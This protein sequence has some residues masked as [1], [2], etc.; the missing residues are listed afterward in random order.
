MVKYNLLEPVSNE[1]ASVMLASA[2]EAQQGNNGS[3]S[4]LNTYWTRFLVEFGK[5]VD[6]KA[7]TKRIGTRDGTLEV[8]DEGCGSSLTLLQA[9]G[10]LK[11]NR[12]GR[13]NGYGITASLEF[14][15]CG[16]P[17]NIRE[18]MLREFKGSQPERKRLEANL[19]GVR[20]NE[21]NGYHRYSPNGNLIRI[22]KGDLHDI[23]KLFPQTQFDLIYSSSTYPHLE[24]GGLALE[25]T[26]NALKQGGVFL[27]DSLPLC[28]IID[29]DGNSLSAEESKNKLEATNKGYKIHMRSDWNPFYVPAI[30]ERETDEHFVIGKFYSGLDVNR[31]RALVTI[32]DST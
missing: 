1:E 12:E 22:V 21:A 6:I 30:I 26:V 20:F 14:L 13:V 5:L 4:I 11:S 8:L 9:I 24:C 28:S 17:Q 25:S 19:E 27:L 2:F 15:N 16:T 29:R 10:E 31:R 18:L 23:G 7:L 3:H 32:L